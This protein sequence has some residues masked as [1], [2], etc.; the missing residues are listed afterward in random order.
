MVNKWKDCRRILAVRL[1]AIGDVLMTEP[2]LRAIKET[3]PHSE[4]TLLTSPQ[5]K[6]A[7]LH[8]PEVDSILTYSAPWMK[9][10]NS[11]DETE[12]LLTTLRK[13][14]FDGAVIFTVYSQ[15][16]FATAFLCKMAGIPLRAAH[17]RENP[18]QLLTDWIPE[19]EPE[20]KIRHEVER[21][22]HLVEALGFVVRNK[23][24]QMDVTAKNPVDT[25]EPFIVVH[26]GATAPSRRYPIE[27]F[28]KVTNQLLEKGLSVVLSGTEAE[29]PLTEEIKKHCPQ[30]VSLAGKLAFSE[31][32]S[33]IKQARLLISNNTSAVHLAS[34]LQTPTVV[35]YALTNPQHT[36]WKVPNRVLFHKTNCAYCYK[37]VCPERHH[38]CLRLV[39]PETVVRAALDLWEEQYAF[40]FRGNSHFSAA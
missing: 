29:T 8:F 1:D 2:A 9:A 21:Q 19:I 20:L 28:C 3:L 16:P 10:S 22:L 36:P 25:S 23:T 38:E 26:P 27:H 18:Y 24:M 11:E 13:G 17:C 7:A 32:A 15:N 35:L 14:N 40:S 6:E 4:L 12:I 5:G 31:F 34:A 39:E 37:S 30:A 33:L